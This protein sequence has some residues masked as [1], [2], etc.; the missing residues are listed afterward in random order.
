MNIDL[1]ISADDIREE[2][3]KGKVVVIIDVLRAT[4]VMVTALSRGCKR[5]IPVREVEEAINLAKLDE[6]NSTT[7]LGG[8]RDGVKVEG[9]KFSNSPLDYRNED[10][11][12]KI[13]VMTTTNGT[14]AIKN[15]EDAD[16]ILI[17]AMINGGAVAKKIVEL[18][19]DVVFVN[20]GTYGQFSMDDF[21]TSGYIIRCIRDLCGADKLDAINLTDI[22]TT[23]QYIYDMNPEIVTYVEKAV[24]YKRLEHLGYH[25]DLRYCFKKD[26]IDIVPKYKDGE[27]LSCN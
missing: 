21:I 5:I 25:E 11:K 26:I 18:N 14:R 13:L 8:E 12:D 7:I 27:I 24:H 4:S 17:G 6:D 15:S 3:L 20:A 10:I 1:I 16:E 23:A 9:F 19:K 2:K 22:A